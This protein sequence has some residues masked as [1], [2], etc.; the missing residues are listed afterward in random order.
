MNYLGIDYGEKR[1][2]IAVSHD[3]GLALPYE[4]FKN[5]DDLLE[6][7]RK[8]CL[9]EGIDKLIVGMPFGLKGNETEQTKLSK[10]FVQDLKQYLNLPII[11]VD[12]RMS[13]GQAKKLRPEGGKKD[14]AS[15]AAVI[16]QGYLDQGVGSR[17]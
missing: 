5:D 17:E 9:I 13:S 2:G 11:E 15:E 4:V 8:L 3:N 14:D 6:S 7:I 10:K 16:L 1:I 12:E